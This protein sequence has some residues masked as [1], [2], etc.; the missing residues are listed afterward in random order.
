MDDFGNNI[1][2][3]IIRTLIMAPVYTTAGYFAYRTGRWFYNEEMR[4]L[5]IISSN[6][7]RR[8][9]EQRIKDKPPK[10]FFWFW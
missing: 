9:R 1:I 5:D 3:N 7:A 2:K 10:R 8:R 4:R 6:E